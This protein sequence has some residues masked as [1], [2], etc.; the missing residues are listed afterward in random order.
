MNNM[1]VTCSKTLINCV[2]LQLKE[3]KNLFNLSEITLKNCLCLQLIIIYIFIS[4]ES[5]K[6][7]VLSL[8]SL[9]SSLTKWW[10]MVSNLENVN[11]NC[12]IFFLLKAWM[13]GKKVNSIWLRQV[14][15]PPWPSYAATASATLGRMVGCVRVNVPLLFLIKSS[16]TPFP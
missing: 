4:K 11:W 14:R 12:I 15:C 8:N 9:L 16:G 2:S 7:N 13:V 6:W 10:K 1:I 5:I 3:K